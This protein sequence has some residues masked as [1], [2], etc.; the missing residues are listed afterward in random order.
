MITII[1]IGFIQSAF[2]AAL[3][4]AKQQKQTS[5]Y[6][7]GVLFVL[8]C[9]HLGVNFVLVTDYRSQFPHL[10][11]TQGSI[12]LL[13]GPLLFFF[14]RNYI[15]TKRQFRY[16]YLL[17]LLPFLLD[18]L[19]HAW[20]FYPKSGEEKVQAVLDIMNGRPDSTLSISLL[21]YSLSPLIY[22]VWSV[23]TL[24]THRQNLKKFYSFTS[25]KLKID[26]LWT[27]TLSMMILSFIA[28]TLNSI[29][30]FSHI[31]N[32][33]ELR[34]IVISSGA[35]W[36]FFL[37]FYSIRKTPFYRSFH[38]EGLNTLDPDASNNSGDREQYRLA[39]K[40][41]EMI[42]RKLQDFL[43]MSRP[44]LNKNLTIGELAEA[45]DVPAYQLSIV[46][47]KHMKTSFFEL[48]NTYRIEELKQRFFE[49]RYSNLT[50]LGMA[51]ECGFS[52]KATFNR[53]FK[54]LTGQTPSEY[55]RQT[56]AA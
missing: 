5:D 28:V 27:L 26:W 22:S 8:I 55:I 17:H 53:I 54:Q 45:I 18:Q 47:N 49:P 30:I 40:D 3:A 1:A 2:F 51:L 31:A 23:N 7:L 46:I 52:S 43:K 36:V 11:G 9:Y 25:E 19:Y 35:A 39:D 13:Y 44:Y 12:S 41:I 48:I 16:R 21:L 42:K 20:F 24:K 33:I 4:F 29:I 56:K 14:V 32:W 50:L 10:I 6:I 38:I 15:R 37:G 34:L